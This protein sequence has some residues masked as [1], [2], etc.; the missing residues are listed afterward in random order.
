MNLPPGKR[1]SNDQLLHTLHRRYFS[2]LLTN[3]ISLPI[4]LA[5]HAIIPRWLGPTDYGSYSYLTAVFNQGVNFVDSSIS[6][7]FYTKLSQRQN[8][9]GLI[10]FYS[11]L[12]ACA[13]CC[14][15]LAVA[16]LHGFGVSDIVWPG[17]SP[18]FVF[19]AAGVAVVSV[20]SQMMSQVV[21]AWGLTVRGEL[22]KTTV[23]LLGVLVLLGMVFAMPPNLL[24]MF[25]Y[26][27]A[28]V[29]ATVATL[30]FVLR[31]RLSLVTLKGGLDREA[32]SNYF[33]EFA[34]Y[35]NPLFVYA[36]V[37]LG[38]GVADRWLLQLFEGTTGS[39]Y[40][41]LS[42]Q[43][44]S[45]AFVFT[46]AL[47]PLLT[48]ELS[49]AF[50]RNAITEMQSLF[51]KAARG[52]FFVG[53]YFAVFI[54]WNAHTVTLAFGGARFVEAASV[55]ALM[56]LY[57]MHQTYG[58]ITGSVLMATGETRLFRNIGVTLLL[59]GLPL[60]YVFIAPSSMF[61][62]GMGARGLAIKTI[63]LQFV[64]VNVQLWFAT[65][66]LK[67]SYRTMLGHQVAVML[68]FFVL[69]WV[70]ASTCSL[71][72]HDAIPFF[73]LSG[74]VY[75]ALT[76][77]ALSVTPFWIGTTLHALGSTLLQGIGRANAPSVDGKSA[78][79][80]KE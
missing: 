27:C 5:T 76:L 67:M 17:Q 6:N 12:L 38:V 61:G 3:A 36:A 54:A 79:S 75:T 52:L 48:R 24:A 69:A 53:A 30:W 10:S 50:V 72:V 18:M 2:K 14:C 8:E 73:L 77:G 70:S 58:Q 19:C 25:G 62:L 1:S 20:F 35:C 56:A 15:V 47:V 29:A 4:G 66:I 43:V 45:V 74:A 68:L 71:M 57:P 34:V 39:A 11:L 28:V 59:V 63:C 23:K 64:G 46:S 31:H 41:G 37:A 22:G 44:A 49:V 13:S 40:Y 51:G 60:S 80:H 26:T 9:R 55:V 7:A 42:S 32:V 65:R 16:L 21:D 33:R 78:F